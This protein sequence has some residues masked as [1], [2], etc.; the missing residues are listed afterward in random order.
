MNEYRTFPRTA[1][2][3]TILFILA[4]SL[5]VARLITTPKPVYSAQV[6][7]TRSSSGAISPDH[8]DFSS[9]AVTY[10]INTSIASNIAGGSGAAI[11]A[12]QHAFATWR[13]APNA[14]VQVSQGANSSLA[15]PA[16]DG[17][18]LVCFVC[19][20]DFAKDSSTLAVTLTTTADAAGQD[21]K[22]NTT[23]KFAG[24][25][26]DADI[27]F[28]PAVQWVTNGRPGSNQEDLQTVAT[29]EIGHFFGLDHSAIV[30][31]VMYPFG[32][33]TLTT[34]SY[35]DLAGLMQLYPKSSPDF[36]TGKISGMVTFANGGGVFGAHVFADSTTNSSPAAGG[37][38]KSAIGALTAPDG[39]YTII[40]LPPDNYTVGVEPLDGPVTNSNVSE[41]APA[42]NRGSVQTNFNTR[43]H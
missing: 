27:I 22:H 8:W 23:S 34:L 28:N 2:W 32:G 5:F 30:R 43:W 33:A 18:N 9:F 6:Q 13:S 14:S 38:R 42:Y 4:A 35:D 25:I 10:Q 19:Q 36:A 1:L 15:A 7:L 39:T 21:T 26:L 20:A 40:G 41:Y 37:I 3:L 31:A 12:V 29:H 11:S 17:V 16:F 24:Q